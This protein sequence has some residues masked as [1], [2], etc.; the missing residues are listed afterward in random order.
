MTDYL[1]DVGRF[2]RSLAIAGLAVVATVLAVLNV[3]VAAL[4]MNPKARA[5][6][7]GPL[8]LSGLT[9]GLLSLA[10]VWMLVRLLRRIRS[11]NGVTTMPLR[12]IQVCGL[13]FGSAVIVTAVIG[14]Q[15][16]FV[17]EGLVIAANMIFLPR[18]L[19]HRRAEET[20]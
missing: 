7:L 5:E 18:L 1:Q 15:V 3:L 11:A 19:R 9:F 13:L 12:F 14:G 17:V 10:T 16:V 2:G 6:I 8:L 20:T 4:L